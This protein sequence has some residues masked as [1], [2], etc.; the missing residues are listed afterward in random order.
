M[1]PLCR[2][3]DVTW[4]AEE[5]T[6]LTKILHSHAQEWNSPVAKSEKCFAVPHHGEIGYFNFLK[7]I[8]KRE[9][10][11]E[12]AFYSLRLLFDPEKDSFI[13]HW[14]DEPH[15]AI[16]YYFVT[17]WC[18]LQI[19][20]HPQFQG[21][22]KVFAHLFQ[23]QLCTREPLLF[24]LTSSRGRFRNRVLFIVCKGVTSFLS[25]PWLNSTDSFHTYLPVYS[26]VPLITGQWL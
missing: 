25:L 4:R 8:T 14:Q 11:K 10:C 7:F 18:R 21:Q 5:L 6:F 23:N 20:P 13:R 16:S 24:C 15:W 2:I 12:N 22:R 3:S 1:H 17:F 9:F 26:S 19:R